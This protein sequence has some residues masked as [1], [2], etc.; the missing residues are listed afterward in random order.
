M[1]EVTRTNGTIDVLTNN[2]Q[3]GMAFLKIAISGLETGSTDAGGNDQDMAGDRN[4]GGAV[5]KV[6]NAIQADFNVV[7]AQVDRDQI[8]VALQVT[9][10]TDTWDGSNSEAL[11]AHVED[12]VQAV[13]NLTSADGSTTLSIGSATV[14]D[15]GFKL[16]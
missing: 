16:A 15:N 7:M 11:A 12:L 10:G 8:S 9:P 13:G 3:P 5:E 6:L 2:I 4:A 1:A 14:T